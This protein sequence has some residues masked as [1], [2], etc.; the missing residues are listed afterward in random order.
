MPKTKK[1]TKELMIISRIKS[2]PYKFDKEIIYQGTPLKIEDIPEILK[3]DEESSNYFYGIHRMNRSKEGVSISYDGYVY[4]GT[5][6]PDFHSR[7]SSIDL[8]ISRD[9][10]KGLL[11]FLSEI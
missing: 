2:P 9:S 1:Q 8:P 3:F 10:K 5:F 7:P 4:D 6:R 11:D